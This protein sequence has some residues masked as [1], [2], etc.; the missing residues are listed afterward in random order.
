MSVRFG[1]P[2][3]VPDIVDGKRVTADEA[4]HVIMHRI[5][6]LLPDRYHGVYEQQRPELPVGPSC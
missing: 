6:S 2:F 1:Q 4:T 5:A 3:R